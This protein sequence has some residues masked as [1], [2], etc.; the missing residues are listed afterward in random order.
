MYPPDRSV[1]APW[2]VADAGVHEV[3]ATLAKARGPVALYA[4]VP[5]CETKCAY[6]DYETVPLASHDDASLSRYVG[7]LLAELGAIANALPQGVEVAGFDIGGGTPGTLAA[8]QFEEILRVV[9]RRFNPAPGFEVSTETTPTLAA[10]EPAKWRRIREAGISR[11]SMGVQTAA[12]ALLSRMNRGLH[13][14]SEIERG[15]AALRAAGFAV[16]NV[17][18]MFALPGLSLESWD[19]TLSSVIALAPDVVTVY[20]TVYKNRGIATLATRDGAAPSVAD[21]GAQY[22][23]AFTRLTAAGFSSRY[24]SVNLSAWYRKRMTESSC[25]SWNCFTGSD[26]SSG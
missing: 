2:R 15:M 25:T 24:G 16:V 20:D 10:A 13:G 8:S 17:D 14:P 1:F 7:A 21:F 18:L 26:E 4:H 19:A 9:E 12:P 5:F 23:H 6:C 3:A 22:D 11:V